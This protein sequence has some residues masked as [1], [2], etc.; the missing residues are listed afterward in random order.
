MSGSAVIEA[1]DAEEAEQLLGEGLV[2]LDASMFDEID[3]D[4]VTADSTEPVV[5]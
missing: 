2:N 1:D 5:K 3:V 4:E